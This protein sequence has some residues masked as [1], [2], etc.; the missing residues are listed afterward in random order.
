MNNTQALS[1][2]VRLGGTAEWNELV[3]DRSGFQREFVRLVSECPQISGRVLDIGCGARLP[4][5]LTGLARR[6]GA[7][8]GVDPDSEVARHPL[9]AQRWHGCL[10]SSAV[11]ESAY[12]LAYAY[13][14]VEHL[15]DPRPFFTKVHQILKPSG[16]FWA[17]TPNQW[18]PF[19]MLSRSI[20][21]IGL[22]GFARRK[23]GRSAS[24]EMC[25]N[26]Y[27]AYYRCNSPGAVQRAIHGLGFS[28]AT[29]YFHP[30]LQWDTYFPRCLRW[31]PR[32]YD[33]VAGT[34]AAS[35]M[36]I[37]IMRLDK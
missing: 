24:G 13:N 3:V 33:F 35:F 12:D 30:C 20:E 25:V 10:E 26:D 32:G 23:L 36:Q 27:P 19:A 18:H 14:V 34:R 9:L 21:L 11:P 37:F 2:W 17:L 22:K 16:V 31:F 1:E 5:P 28:R 4:E 7:L 6:F 29:F 15:G 8:D